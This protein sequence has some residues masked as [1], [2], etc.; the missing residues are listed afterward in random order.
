[1]T[2]TV[3]FRCQNCGRRFESE[4]LSPEEQLDA[5]REDRPTAPVHCPECNRTEIR[6]GWE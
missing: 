2:E 3:R 5:R 6:R 1:M 4:V